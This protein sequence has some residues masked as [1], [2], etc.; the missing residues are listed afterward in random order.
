MADS[1]TVSAVSSTCP[2]TH[3]AAS[4]RTCQPMIPAA[5]DAS[6]V[7]VIA[8]SWDRWWKQVSGCACPAPEGEDGFGEFLPIYS[9]TEAIVTPL[10]LEDNTPWARHFKWRAMNARA[11]PPLSPRED[12]KAWLHGAQRRALLTAL[13]KE[14]PKAG[15]S[16][17]EAAKKVA[18]RQVQAC[19]QEVRAP[20]AI[21]SGFASSRKTLSGSVNRCET[22]GSLRNCTRSCK[23]NWPPGT[24]ITRKSQSDPST[25]HSKSFTLDPEP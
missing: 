12:T 11:P 14:T 17:F 25:L 5:A 3:A 23:R 21:S 18:L 13:D 24:S 6:P 1:E 2:P 20:L 16:E 22:L 15:A 7:D 4:P 9:E 10:G 19:E 8:A